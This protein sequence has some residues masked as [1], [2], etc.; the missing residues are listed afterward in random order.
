MLRAF[1]WV[2]ALA[3]GLVAACGRNDGGPNPGLKVPD[4]PPSSKGDPLKLP[5]KK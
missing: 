1:R 5:D 4:V 3:L 2:V